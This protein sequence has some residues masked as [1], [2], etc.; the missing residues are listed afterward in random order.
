MDKIEPQPI[1]TIISEKV[2]VEVKEGDTVDTAK[3][4][5]LL[6]S[7]V[8]EFEGETIG[9]WKAK[10]AELETQKLYY[11]T[12]FAKLEAQ[13]NAEIQKFQELINKYQP[14]VEAKISAKTP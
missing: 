6:T 13:A 3:I 2:E 1:D 12:E 7:E 4:T 5:S 10:I 11:Q 9:N 14:E 8:P